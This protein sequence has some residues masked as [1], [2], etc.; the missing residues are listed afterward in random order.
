MTRSTTGWLLLLLA[1]AGCARPAAHDDAAATETVAPPD[2]GRD[3]LVAALRSL[4]SRIP[5]GAVVDTGVGPSPYDYPAEAIAAIARDAGYATADRRDVADCTDACPAAVVRL[6]PPAFRS[7]AEADATVTW[8]GMPR[9]QY[10]MRSGRSVTLRLA[11]RDGGWEV[12]E[13]LADEAF[14]MAPRPAETD[15]VR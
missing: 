14:V 15:T 2:A 12:T 13:Q 8:T 10:R 3:V 11:L 7:A 6:R 4:A 9:G 5:D 1:L